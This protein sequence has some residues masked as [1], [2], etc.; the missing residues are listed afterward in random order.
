MQI[1]FEPKYDIGD[2]AVLRVN[3]ERKVVIYGYRIDNVSDA[4]EVRGF[5]YLVY[6]D[7]G[8]LFMYTDKDLQLFESVSNV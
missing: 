5:M 4:G 7:E 6:D 2:I 8:L 3:S 1:L